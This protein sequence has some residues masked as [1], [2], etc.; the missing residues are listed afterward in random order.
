MILKP[1]DILVLLKLLSIGKRDWTYAWLGV[2]LGMSPSQ[3]H[4]AVKRVLAAQLAVY[5]GD[6]I[7][8]N[9]RNLEEFLVHGVKY[10][11]VP[12]RGELTRGMPTGYAASP[13]ADQFAGTD[14]PPPVWPTPDG[15]VRGQ[16][17]SPLYPLAPGAAAKDPV[18]YELLALVD[19]IRGG[20]ARERD[21]GIKELKMRLER[22]G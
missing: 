16:A 1:Q 2:E 7:V 20:R 10:A 4:A 18:L 9:R 8:P 6:Q 19:A 22:H 12:E 17:F 14:E 21:L 3:L 15:S 11:F 13:L 5:Q